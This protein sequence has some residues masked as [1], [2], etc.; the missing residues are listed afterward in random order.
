MNDDRDNILAL[1][2]A[3]AKNAMSLTHDA[4]LLLLGSRWAGAYALATLAVEEAGKAWLCHGQLCGIHGVNRKILDNHVGKAIAAREM[5]AMLTEASKREININ[6]V[7]DEHHDYAADDAHLLRKLGLYVDLTDVGIAGGP[8]SVKEEDA[9]ASVT[10]AVQ[11]SRA[12][13]A[14]TDFDL[15]EGDLGADDGQL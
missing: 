14:V 11:T 6:E 8:D 3:A 4:Q 2:D 5:L 10:L 7:F 1:R 9:R 13:A 15:P 12:A